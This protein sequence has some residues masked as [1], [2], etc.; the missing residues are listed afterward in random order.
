MA[1]DLV[2]R[3]ARLRDGA[4]VDIAIDAGRFVEIGTGLAFTGRE[5]R[6]LAGAVVLPGFTD[7]HQHVDKAYTLDL[8]GPAD[9]NLDARERFRAFKPTMTADDVYRR[10]HAV[11]ERLVR[12]GTC[13]LRTHVDT[14]DLAELRGVEGTLALRQEYADRVRMQMVVFPRGDLNVWEP[15][16][17]GLL[18]RALDLGCDVV[19]GVPNVNADPR[20]YVDTMLALAQEYGVLVD[21]HVEENCDADASV[22]EYVA[23]ATRAAGLVGRVTCSH[24]CSLSIVSDA[25]AD[26]VI[27]K[28]KAAGIF[29]A[30]QPL[31]NLYLQGG[32]GRVPGPRG[33]TRVRDL[34]QAGVTVCCASDNIQDPF[35]PYGNGD[36]LLAALVAGLALR[37]GSP[38]DQAAL[39]DSITV[40]G[41]S[42]MGLE[43]YGLRP[44]A[45]ADLVALACATPGNVIAEQPTRKLVVLG[46][47]CMPSATEPASVP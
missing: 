36:P 46:G 4:L 20:R 9:G 6:D 32:G 33:L 11:M 1:V 8:L 45:R 16:I 21:F 23:D 35:N 14:D 10:G 17:H 40:A 26:R 37:I 7:L 30:T 29:I 43:D 19:G 18:R 42:A 39:L 12:H 25:A 44:G 2:L 3:R 34:W 5:E 47:R 41:A 22:L 31:T 13:A 24:C 28:V 38:A 15:A 27:A